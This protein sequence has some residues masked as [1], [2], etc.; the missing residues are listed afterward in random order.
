MLKNL[1]PTALSGVIYVVVKPSYFIFIKKCRQGCNIQKSRQGQL[2][3]AIDE[4]NKSIGNQESL[5]QSL[6]V[7]MIIGYLI[8]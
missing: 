6:Y 3:A 5:V 7:L 1:V 2:L 4:E 8:V